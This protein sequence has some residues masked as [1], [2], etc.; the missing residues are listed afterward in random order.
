MLTNALSAQRAEY[1]LA[2]AQLDALKRE[3]SA[4]LGRI[5]SLQQ[6][7]RSPGAD[8]SRISAQLEQVAQ[9]SLTISNR[10]GAQAEAL[11][12]K[13]ETIQAT[14][15]PEAKSLDYRLLQITGNV[16]VRRG[17]SSAPP[18]KAKAGMVLLPSDVITTGAKSSARIQVPNGP[19]LTAGENT[20]LE[21]SA[22]AQT[23]AFLKVINGI[24]QFLRP[25][26]TTTVLLTFLN[27]ILIFRNA[28]T[29]PRK[30]ENNTPVGVAGIK[31]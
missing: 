4:V 21:L 24:L 16:Y 17:R 29:G 31:G 25:R 3:N 6:E 19:V 8:Q 15:A 11:S 14:T 10:L 30:Y 13:I 20:R 26:P 22:L 1:S 5:E 2:L 23:N 7:L 9:R 12:N 18:L 27:L 28:T